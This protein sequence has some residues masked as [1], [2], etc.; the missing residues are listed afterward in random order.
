GADGD[1]RTCYYCS[2]NHIS[3]ADYDSNCGNPNYDGHSE[4]AS[5]V[6]G[7][8]IIIYDDGNIWRGF[9]GK[10]QENHDDEC[11]RVTDN[12]D[13]WGTRCWC[14]TDRCN[15]HLCENCFPTTTTTTT[16]TTP[17]TT[18][19]TQS[20]PGNDLTCYN[21]IA[22]PTTDENTEVVSDE[23][24]LTC[25]TIMTGDGTIIRDGGYD[26]HADG[27][28]FANGGVTQC[29]CTTPLCNDAGLSCYSC[30]DCPTVNQNTTVVFD[31]NFK[32]CVTTLTDQGTIIR[33]GGFDV[34]A[35]GEC[36]VDGTLTQ[37]H[38]T[39]FLCNDE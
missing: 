19:S 10:H 8:F 16:T 25:V 39:N 6:R 9:E 32:T 26:D 13:G 12:V 35:D 3:N 2:N 5:F 18:T 34:H 7:C 24:F 22:C 37:C 30:V 23:N 21:C 31:E 20:P 29:H 36:I 33:S 27:D 28:C 1:H 38:C 11:Q 15:S 14:P 17:T 4:R